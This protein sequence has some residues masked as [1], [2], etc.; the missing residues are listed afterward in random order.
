M[1]SRPSGSARSVQSVRVQFTFCCRTCWYRF[2]GSTGLIV[3]VTFR[4]LSWAC[5]N[6]AN[7]NPTGV[8]SVEN[9]A[10]NPFWYPASASNRLARSGS[11]VYP[12][13]V[14]LYH[15][16]I[17]GVGPLAT[18]PR[19]PSMIFTNSSRST[20]YAMAWRS[21]LLLKGGRSTRHWMPHQWP[22]GFSLTT[23]TPG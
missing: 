6:W 18:L 20:P 19:P 10:E 4:R 15:H 22:E 8:L 13:T 11:Y 23:F 1:R 17:D 7:C 5:S 12:R 2:E 21:A 14:G 9:S 3:S 16:T